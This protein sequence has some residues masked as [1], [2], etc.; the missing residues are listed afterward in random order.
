MD[1]S[2]FGSFQDFCFYVEPTSTKGSWAKVGQE[3]SRLG[4]KTVCF[5]IED[6]CGVCEMILA[7]SSLEH[8]HLKE[9][10]ACPHEFNAIKEV[11][12]VIPKKFSPI[13]TIDRIRVNGNLMG[14]ILSSCAAGVIFRSCTI[15]IWGSNLKI[16]DSHVRQ[17]EFHKVF[18]ANGTFAMIFNGLEQNK[19]VNRVKLYWPLGSAVEMEFPFIGFVQNNTSMSCL[20]VDQFPNGIW[21]EV[22]KTALPKN[23]TLQTLVAPVGALTIEAAAKFISTT[24]TLKSLVIN[25]LSVFTGR[26]AQVFGA[27]KKN[28]SVKNLGISDYTPDMNWL[29]Y[30]GDL[31]Q[32]NST[33][34]EF[35]F[36]AFSTMQFDSRRIPIWGS[37]L[38]TNSSLVSFDVRPTSAD[39]NIIMVGEL[40]HKNH[41]PDGNGV[42]SCA[43][44]IFLE[45]GVHHPVANLGLQCLFMKEKEFVVDSFTTAKRK[46]WQ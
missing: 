22:L 32:E 45:Y 6:Y 34:E 30:F 46:R 8:V 42:L 3:L 19:H 9:R 21:L 23:T 2:G 27:L 24:K 13:W 44:L 16:E 11:F 12:D 5:A 36:F 4:I 25:F 20:E 37:A 40:V 17:W 29:W 31:L 35:G 38:I 18:F 14:K 33:L 1:I 7:M 26:Y 15:D 10:G 39:K 43:F 41:D 28:T